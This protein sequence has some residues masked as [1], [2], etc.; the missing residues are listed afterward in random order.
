V[1]GSLRAVPALAQLGADELELLVAR[2]TEIELADGETLIA[3][4]DA[5]HGDRRLCFLLEGRCV[6][7]REE[8]PGGP[9]LEFDV[10]APDLVGLVAAVD[11]GDRTADVVARGPVRARALSFEDLESLRAA[12]GRLAFE[13]ELAIARQ[14]VRDFVG[15]NDRMTSFD[16]PREAPERPTWTE[17]ESYSGL[18]A[19]RA[20]LS[21]PRTLRGIAKEVADA[22]RVRRRVCLRGRGLSFDTH[23]MGLQSVCSTAGLNGIQVDPE[24]YT[25]TVGP[26][27]SWG[28]IVRRAAA[29]GLVP[30]V[31]VSGSEITAAGTASTN[32]LSRFSPRWGKEGRWIRSL[33]VLLADG[34]RVR[35]SRDEH[36]DLFFSIVGGLGLLGVIVSITYELLPVGC[37]PRV[38]SSV[39]RVPDL[40]DLPSLL[41]IEPDARPDADTRYGLIALRGD[42]MRSLVTTSRYVDGA[43]LRTMLPHRQASA[44]RLPIELAIHS[45]DGA[46]QRFW[47][48][49]YDH[50]VDESSPYVDELH[51]YTFFMDGNVAT[52]RAAAGLGIAVRTVQQTHIIPSGTAPDPLPDF[53]RRCAA[54]ARAEDL[55]S[56][57]ALIDVLHLPADEGFALSSTRGRGGYALTLT[58]EGIRDLAHAHRVRACCLDLARETEALGGRVHLTKNVFATAE[59][60]STTYAEGIAQMAEAKRTYDPNGRFGSEFTDRLFPMLRS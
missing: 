4:G 21:R 2:T 58:F 42:E 27:A 10:E 22:T 16:E 23:A 25:A 49:A 30:P 53:A 43:P 40:E 55:D 59:D 33:D 6:V 3:R 11:G 60:L 36:S 9:K 1:T 47:N 48:F 19:L 52:H 17:L 31:V 45:V 41:R 57:L 29:Y 13:L 12:G 24:R 56:S 8:I 34:E 44:A 14:L 51:G 20:E 46:G 28:E 39:R 35:A 50:Y 7:L 26:G 5:S 18:H 37:T 15:M 38:Q 32:S 54:R